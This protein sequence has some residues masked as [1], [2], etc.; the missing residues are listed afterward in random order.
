M[1]F[2]NRTLSPQLLT[3]EKRA[4]ASMELILPPIRAGRGDRGEG[5][6]RLTQDEYADIAARDE[7]IC[8]A[9]GQAEPGP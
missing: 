3:I 9:G 2:G 1:S 6:P 5:Q 8:V 7:L 4:G